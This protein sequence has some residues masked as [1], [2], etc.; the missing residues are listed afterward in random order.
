[1]ALYGARAGPQSGTDGRTVVRA[2]QWG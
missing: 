2:K 1:M